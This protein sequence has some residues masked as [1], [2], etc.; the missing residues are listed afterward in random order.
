[1][2]HSV[3]LT[4]HLPTRKKAV[5]RNETTNN[6]NTVSDH[7]SG[8]AKFPGISPTLHGMLPHIMHT[9]HCI[10]KTASSTQ[11]LS[12][13]PNRLRPSQNPVFIQ[14]KPANCTPHPDVKTAIASRAFWAAGPKLCNNL[15]SFVK[16]SCSYDVFKSHLFAQVFT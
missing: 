8:T 16:S 13:P 5:K 14:H 6:S 4:D 7:S 15:L 10:Y 3:R 11:V 2:P 9:N 1:M 12:R